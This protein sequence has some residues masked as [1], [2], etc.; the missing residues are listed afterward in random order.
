[1][2]A[3][4]CEVLGEMYTGDRGDEYADKTESKKER[5]TIERE[6]IEKIQTTKHSHQRGLAQPNEAYK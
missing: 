3:H 6:H 4:A 1:M 5:H 2:S